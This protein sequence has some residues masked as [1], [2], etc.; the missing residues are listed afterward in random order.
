MTTY[1][2]DYDMCHFWHQKPKNVPRYA[3]VSWNSFVMW[4]YA[5]V[6]IGEYKSWNVVMYYTTIFRPL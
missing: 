6:T 1:P 4:V 2:T 5:L 3:T